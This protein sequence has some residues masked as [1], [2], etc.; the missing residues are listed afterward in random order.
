MQ[1]PK[2]SRLV[3]ALANAFGY[4]VDLLQTQKLSSLC[5]PQPDQFERGVVGLAPDQ[6]EIGLDMAIA[7]ILPF[8]SKSVIMVGRFAYRKLWNVSRWGCASLQFNIGR[9]D[10]LAPLLGFI[11]NELAEGSRRKHER[12]A[13]QI[14]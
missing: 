6:D 10:H 11:G 3:G 7:A 13:P 4:D 9:P 1:W 5:E 8:A 2:N 14:G 12:R